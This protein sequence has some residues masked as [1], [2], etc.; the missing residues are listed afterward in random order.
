MRWD[1][2]GA[3]RALGVP[4]TVVMPRFAPLVKVARCR[5]FGATVILHGET[6]DE[7]RGEAVS[8]WRRNGG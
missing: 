3:G 6:F 2:H 4:V 8:G 1:W 7:A 5:L